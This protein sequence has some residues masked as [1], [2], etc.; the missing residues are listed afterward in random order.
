MHTRNHDS[1]LRRQSSLGDAKDSVGKAH[2]AVSEALSNPRDE[3]L[4]SADRAVAKAQHA[5]A[6]MTQTDNQMAAGQVTASLGDAERRLAQA[7]DAAQ[8]DRASSSI[9]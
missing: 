1:S 9:P 7:K 3:F 5:V 8:Q 4:K 2:N 6:A